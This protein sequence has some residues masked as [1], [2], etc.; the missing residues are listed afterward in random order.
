MS[1]GFGKPP[2]QYP[3]NGRW[4]SSYNW[5]N[6]FYGTLDE[7][8][9]RIEHCFLDSGEHLA[10]GLLLAGLEEKLGNDHPGLKALETR[11][12]Q[13]QD[14]LAKKIR[15]NVRDACL[16]EGYVEKGHWYIWFQGRLPK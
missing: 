6:G 3:P 5:E 7:C 11:I 8:L 12:E 14:S 2:K 16:R 1:K 15:A 9:D 13:E 4:F 10:T